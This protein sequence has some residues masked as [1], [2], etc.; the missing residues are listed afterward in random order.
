M[1]AGTAND[2]P[3]G[4]VPRSEPVLSDPTIDQ[5]SSMR[6]LP[7]SARHG[8][9]LATESGRLRGGW[10]T[11]SK[12]SLHQPLERALGVHRLTNPGQDPRGRD[13]GMALDRELRP[14]SVESDDPHYRRA[15]GVEGLL[16]HD[17]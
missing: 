5:S 10:P 12:R 8:D 4:F 6:Q 13:E 15:Q 3:A 2:P 1:A 9:T 17:S 11:Y 16:G 7:T 14:G